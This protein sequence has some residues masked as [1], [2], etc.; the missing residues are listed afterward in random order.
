MSTKTFL[1]IHG[2]IYTVFGLGLFF[3]PNLLWPNYGL[4]LNDK[5]SVFLSQHTTIFLGGIA[6]I[7]FLFRDVEEKSVYARKILTSVLCTNILGVLI[8]LYAI[9]TGI[10]YGFGWSDP[11][12]FTLLSILSY[13]KLKHN[14]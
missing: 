8:T 11:A 3:I 5:Y 10:F 14:Q 7:S 13:V 9:Y 6:I 4:E 12:F 2:V 1:T